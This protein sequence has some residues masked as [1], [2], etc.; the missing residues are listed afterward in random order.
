MTS[1]IVAITILG[2]LL[3]KLEVMAIFVNVLAVNNGFE[4]EVLDWNE[5]KTEADAS[6]PMLVTHTR[7]LL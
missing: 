3:P 6:R 7:F 1:H 4:W 2:I 5:K